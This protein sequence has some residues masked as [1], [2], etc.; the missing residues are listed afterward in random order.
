MDSYFPHE[1]VEAFVDEGDVQPMQVSHEGQRVL[2][3][4]GGLQAELDFFE[5]LILQIRVDE[6]VDVFVGE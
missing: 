3:G 4:Q 6:F 2:A 5:R 1:I